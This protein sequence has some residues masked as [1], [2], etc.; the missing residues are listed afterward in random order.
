MAVFRLGS[1]VARRCIANQHTHVPG[2]H[3]YSGDVDFLRRCDLVRLSSMVSF[4]L[5]LC[6]E[7]SYQYA[8]FLDTCWH[9]YE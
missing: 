5:S 1:Q 6:L 9:D 7:V 3:Q 8:R 2:R 4:I